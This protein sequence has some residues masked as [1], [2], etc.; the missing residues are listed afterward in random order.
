MSVSATNSR[1]QN[2][3][4]RELKKTFDMHETVWSTGST[5]AMRCLKF[6]KCKMFPFTLL[7]LRNDTA[8][9]AISRSS[10]SHIATFLHV[11]LTSV[12]IGKYKGA[13]VIANWTLRRVTK[14][15]PKS[16]H[17]LNKMDSRDMRGPRRCTVCGREGHSRSRCPQRACPSSAGGH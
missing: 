11:A 16:T 1:I 12:L 14:E 7:T 13:K 3:H 4:R 8:T 10:D 5:G 15:R 2:L 9:V 6:A 17:Y